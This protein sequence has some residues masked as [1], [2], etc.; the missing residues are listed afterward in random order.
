[1]VLV[2]VGVGGA[3]CASH[4]VGLPLGMIEISAGLAFDVMHGVV[5]A[6]VVGLEIVEVF[7]V[8]VFVPLVKFLIWSVVVLVIVEAVLV[9]LMVVGAEVVVLM[10]VGA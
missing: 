5:V 1:M 7:V 3:A 10:I 9:V 2:V 6:V 4:S 8:V